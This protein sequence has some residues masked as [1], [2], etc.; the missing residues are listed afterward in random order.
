MKIRIMSDLHL[1]LNEK[2]HLEL[3]K[4]D[5]YTLIAGDLGPD[6]KQNVKWI[7]NNISKGA[8]I[9]GNHDAY[10]HD[11]TP[12]E[13]VKEFYHK[14]FPIDSDITYFDN[15]VGV[16]S[17]DLDDKTILVADVLYTD[18]TYPCF[19]Y[20]SE[21]KENELQKRNMRRVTPKMS[22]SYMN[23]FMFFT[24][25]GKY[26]NGK[27]CIHGGGLYYIKPEMYVE[28]F[29]NTFSKITDIIEHNTDK[30]IILMT[31]HCLSPKCQ[32]PSFDHRELNSAYITNKE[33]WILD[34]PNIRMVVSGH[35][36]NV[37][38]FKIGNTL[39]S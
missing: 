35:I 6:Y 4:D 29:N 8:F 21:L 13:D 19:H 7:K 3:K 28:H 32:T 24:R 25:N 30:D 1:S 5:I 11:N 17:K 10:T 23:D 9:S 39:M 27:N 2:Y 36:H 20:D 26:S 33:K 14:K 37:R 12:I 18:F 15:D 31:H 22:G 38:D 16:I 34:H